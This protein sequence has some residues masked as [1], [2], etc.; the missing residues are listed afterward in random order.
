MSADAW[1]RVMKLCWRN[2]EYFRREGRGG[3]PNTTS[4]G[5]STGSIIVPQLHGTLTKKSANFSA[6]ATGRV[7]IALTSLVYNISLSSTESAL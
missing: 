1:T 6:I 5:F 2:K 4:C 7:F 3:T